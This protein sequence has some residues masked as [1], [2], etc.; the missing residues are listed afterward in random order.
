ME[1]EVPSPDLLAELARAQATFGDMHDAR[2]AALKDLLK[3]RPKYRDTH[4]DSRR[5]AI[6]ILLQT[7]SREFEDDD[8]KI[9]AE[10]MAEAWSGEHGWDRHTLV[11]ALG[12]DR[13]VPQAPP[14]QPQV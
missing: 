7:W 9:A 13:N 5:S 6:L 12:R 14:G 1:K 11:D 3:D 2:V 10:L 4:T 8:Y